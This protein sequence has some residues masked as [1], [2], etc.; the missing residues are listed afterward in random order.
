MAKDSDDFDVAAMAKARG[1]LVL[2]FDGDF[3]NIVNFPPHQFGG[4]V[5]L[6]MRDNAAAYQSLLDQLDRLLKEHAEQDWYVGR[7]VV[8][9]TYRFRWR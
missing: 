9:D 3:G 5:L 4:I 1:E 2:T 8:V 6:M 7:T